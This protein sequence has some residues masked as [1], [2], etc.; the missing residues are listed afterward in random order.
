[1]RQRKQFVAPEVLQQV[2]IHLE[3]DLLQ[4]PSVR[5]NT[6]LVIPGQEIEEH[7]LEGA[8]SYWE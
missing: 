7:D 1:M 3:T 4:G 6:E 5:V 8:N 2:E